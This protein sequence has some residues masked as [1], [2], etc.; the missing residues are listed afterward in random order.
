MI[1]ETA[2]VNNVGENW[3]EVTSEIKSTCSSCQQIDTCGSGQVAKVFP[4]KSLS[5]RL[6][7]DSFKPTLA[8]GDKVV[9][10]IPQDKLLTSLARVYG[11]PLAFLIAFAGFGQ[12]L[13]GQTTSELLTIALAIGGGYLGYRIAQYLENQ[14]NHQANLAPYLVKKL[15]SHDIP[16]E[17]HH[18]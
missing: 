5:L 18:A 1:Q 9:I 12:V 10:A 16:V 4:Q 3:V 14:Q 13:F 17:I 8:V 2:T 7:T 15:P 6:S 11:L